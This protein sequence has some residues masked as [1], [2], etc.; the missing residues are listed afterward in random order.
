MKEYSETAEGLRFKYGVGALE[1][2]RAYL[3]EHGIKTGTIYEDLFGRF[4]ANSATIHWRGGTDIYV[5]PARVISSDNIPKFNLHH[6]DS[7][8]E[9]LKAVRK[10]DNEWRQP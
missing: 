4:I 3:D 5:T 1:L 10:Y 2:T 8:P 9:I 6:P 7:L